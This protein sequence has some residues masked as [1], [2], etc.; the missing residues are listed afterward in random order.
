MHLSNSFHMD[1]HVSSNFPIV[2]YFD[3]IVWCKQME[4]S[5]IGEPCFAIC[6]NSSLNDSTRTEFQYDTTS[7]SIAIS[8][9]C[10]IRLHCSHTL[11][12]QHIE[13]PLFQSVEYQYST[14]LN[15]LAILRI[16]IT[17]ISRYIH[18]TMQ[19]LSPLLEF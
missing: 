18:F 19:E 15:K 2:Y 13:C 5:F 3:W 4:D 8:V 1:I 14:L 9:F 16:W 12:R 10:L 7:C 6:A 17:L 11:Q